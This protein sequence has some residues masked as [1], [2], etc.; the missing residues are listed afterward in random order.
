MKSIG[1]MPKIPAG[2]LAK[3][4]AV[5]FLPY[6]QYEMPQAPSITFLCEPSRI[7]NGGTTAPPGSASI[8]RFPPVS[9]S[10]RSAKN[11]R[12]SCV[13]DD[14]GTADCT[15]RVRGC[16]ASAVPAN[17]SVAEAAETRA[18]LLRNSFSLDVLLPLEECGQAMR[19]SAREQPTAPRYFQPERLS[20]ACSPARDKFPRPFE[21]A[22][23]R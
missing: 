21:T 16:W 6:H 1:S 20:A 13:V 2:V 8:L 18:T 9:L 12:A 17:A 23:R 7:S 4:V 11:L 5:T 10:T 19:R 22:V 15:L 3:S 14:G